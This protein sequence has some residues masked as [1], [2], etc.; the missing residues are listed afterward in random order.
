MKKEI[1]NRISRSRDIGN[2]SSGNVEKTTFFDKIFSLLF[3]KN[4]LRSVI[5]KQN[6][7]SK[8]LFYAE[9]GYEIKF[10]RKWLV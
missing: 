3:F 7:F 4:L 6:M 9:S 1:E 10:C 5:T 2:L 8:A